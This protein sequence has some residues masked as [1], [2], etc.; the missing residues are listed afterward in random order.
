MTTRTE[1]TIQTD[2]LVISDGEVI[3]DYTSDLPDPTETTSY[4]EPWVGIG[5]SALVA[6][7]TFD[8]AD[9][10]SFISLG[11]GDAMDIPN[12]SPPDGVSEFDFGHASVP[13]FEGFGDDAWG[14]LLPPTTWGESIADFFD[15]LGD[16][17]QSYYNN[18][19]DILEEVGDF[20]ADETGWDGFRVGASLLA[21]GYRAIGAAANWAVDGI[22]GLAG[23]I[24]DS[25]TNPQTVLDGVQAALDIVGFIPVVGEVADLANAA[26]SLA[27]GDYVGAALSLVS[28]IPVV[29]DAI[30]KGGK[31]ARFAA[32]KADDVLA[33]GRKIKCKVTGKGCFTAGTPVWVSAFVATDNASHLALE[34]GA[35][36]VSTLTRS[37]APPITKQPIESV[38]IGS[39]VSGDNPRPWEYDDELPEPDSSWQLAKFSLQK[40]DGSWIDVEMIRPAEYWQRN[41]ASL[42]G[43]VEI[44]FPELNAS[45]LARIRSFE[46]AP[47]IASGEGNV[48]T[49]QITTRQANDL[50]EIRLDSP[51]DE[52]HT[53]DT[54]TGTPQHPIW[55]VDQQDWVELGDLQV[56][57]RLLTDFGPASIKATRR[58][59]TSESVYNIE[60]HGHH[61]YQIGDQGIL[62]HNAGPKSYNTEAFRKGWDRV[63]GKKKSLRDQYLG[64]TPGKG[65]RTGKE[66]IERMRASKK[67]RGKGKNMRFE[68]KGKWYKVKNADM[69]HIT[70]AVSYW[71]KTG[72]F[73]GAKSKEVRRWMLNSKNYELQPASINRRMGALLG[74]SGTRYLPPV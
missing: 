33:A 17:I 64:R 5:T 11:G 29:G 71:N 9:G 60:V 35:S 50:V 12:A 25:I 18:F 26:I 7:R 58:I 19:A 44:Q 39:R 30:G 4:H 31:L 21:D 56:G 15:F 62:V 69:G 36:S 41:G 38:V 40:D 42:G 55:S 14:D 3:E 49:A 72:R 10:K 6:R 43:Y 27:R 32:S 70:D 63:F 59:A 66:V 34:T 53:A 24:V 47:A 51:D 61:L 16:G 46:P 20:L 74:N 13:G 48:V 37:T 28:A 52:T 23:S 68:Y 8:L 2:R 22:G 1:S 67:I 57:E 73:L 45:G 65:S 54:F